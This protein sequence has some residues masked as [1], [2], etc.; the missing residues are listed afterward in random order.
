MPEKLEILDLMN[1]SEAVYL[2]TLD[3]RIPRLRALVNLRR[4]DLCPGSAAFCRKEGLTCYGCTSAASSKVAELRAHPEAS[5]YYC[6]PRN[7]RG[8]TL[9]GRVEILTD[10]Q[11]KTALWD[12]SWRMYWCGPEDPDYV[13]LRLTPVEAYGWW[14]A[15]PFRLD[16]DGL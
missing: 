16:L 2:A 8:V 13:V 14:G 4:S 15:R 10:Q 5:L 9:S 1:S 11:L 7:V 12:E 3:G 6:D